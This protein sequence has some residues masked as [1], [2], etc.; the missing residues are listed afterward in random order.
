MS[1]KHDQISE[2]W[3]PMRVIQM[4]SQTNNSK[5]IKIKSRQDTNNGMGEFENDMSKCLNKIQ[6]NRNG[7]EINVCYADLILEEIET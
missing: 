1:S 6:E 7:Q 4:K 5:V 2:S 3:L